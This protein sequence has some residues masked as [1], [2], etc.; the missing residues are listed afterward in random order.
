[1][2]V[3]IFPQSVEGSQIFYVEKE[4]CISPCAIGEFQWFLIH[5]CTVYRE[6]GYNF[7]YNS[8]A[9]LR[10]GDIQPPLDQI[11]FIFIK[12]IKAI[13]RDSA[14]SKGRTIATSCTYR[15]LSL[16]FVIM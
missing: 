16:V 7:Q 3:A 2:A 15:P 4:V 6:N 14:L 9:D 1:M 10:A 13:S 11:F 8:F 5:F 12:E